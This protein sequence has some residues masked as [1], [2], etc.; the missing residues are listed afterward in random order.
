VIDNKKDL[1]SSYKSPRCGLSTSLHETCLN[2]IINTYRKKVNGIIKNHR[3]YYVFLMLFWFCYVVCWYNDWRLPDI[4]E[5]LKKIDFPEGKE[6]LV[7]M[8]CFSSDGI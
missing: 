3:N 6:V 4:A 8:V 1:T 7:T 5:L 2:C